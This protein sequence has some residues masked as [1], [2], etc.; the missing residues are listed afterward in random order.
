MLVNEFEKLRSCGFS[1]ILKEVFVP[2][3]QPLEGLGQ[4]YS[5]YLSLLPH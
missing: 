4:Q 5:Q 1:K 3:T 2:H